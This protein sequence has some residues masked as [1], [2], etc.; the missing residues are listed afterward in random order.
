MSLIIETTGPWFGHQDPL[1]LKSERV[2]KNLI[3]DPHKPRQATVKQEVSKL[4][5]GR[6]NDCDIE[7]N[8]GHVSRHHAEL[9][10][11]WGGWYIKDLKSTNG[12]FLLVDG[13]LQQI[14]PEKPHPIERGLRIV[15]GKVR[16][17]AEL[18]FY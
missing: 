13:E 8:A 15:F 1:V 4:I 18:I 10:I 16:D 6:A 12:T 2:Q 17:H 14:S 9:S 11:H 3:I 5:I 7:L